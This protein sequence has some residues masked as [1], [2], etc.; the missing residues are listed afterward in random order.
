MAYSITNLCVNCGACESECPVSAIAPGSGQ[1][2][3]DTDACIECNACAVACPTD[4]AIE[5]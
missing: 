5:S 3:I 4:G 2:V 1:Y